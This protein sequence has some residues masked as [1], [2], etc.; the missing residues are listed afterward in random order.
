MLLSASQWTFAVWCL[1]HSTFSLCSEQ[2]FVV[3][4][5]NTLKLFKLKKLVKLKNTFCR[6]HSFYDLFLYNNNFIIIFYW[7]DR[8]RRLLHFHSQL[9]TFCFRRCWTIWFFFVLCCCCRWLAPSWSRISKKWLISWLTVP[10]ETET[11]GIHESISIKIAAP[12]NN[13]RAS[14][15]LAQ[16]KAQ[17]MG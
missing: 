6:A 15:I 10:P 5:K 8:H 2:K 17:K 12:L 3:L 11:W 1:A 7:F 13:L 4:K 16:M 9:S 14:S